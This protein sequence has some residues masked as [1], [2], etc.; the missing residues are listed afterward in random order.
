MTSGRKELKGSN[1][2]NKNSINAYPLNE[3]NKS[4]R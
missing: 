2:G 4:A 1:R 3:D